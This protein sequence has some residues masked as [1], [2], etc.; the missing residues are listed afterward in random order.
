MRFAVVSLFAS[1]L[2]TLV[3]GVAIA[4]DAG[5]L[6]ALA[7]RDPLCQEVIVCSDLNPCKCTGNKCNHPTSGK[8]E[9]SYT[10]SDL[11]DML[12]LMDSSPPSPEV[13]FSQHTAGESREN[14]C[15]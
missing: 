6:N 4:P 10:L 15:Y 5:S 2:V 12:T 11:E 8:C 1:T 9:V 14:R 7:K 3:L 13:I